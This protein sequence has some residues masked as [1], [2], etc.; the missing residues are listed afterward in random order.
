MTHFVRGEVVMNRLLSDRLD[1]L[2]VISAEGPAKEEFKFDQALLK[3]SREKN[4][5]I[6]SKAQAKA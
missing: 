2:M 1:T 3:W 6:F 5:R 4:R